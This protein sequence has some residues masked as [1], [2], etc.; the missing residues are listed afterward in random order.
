VSVSAFKTQ[1][2]LT[3]AARESEDAIN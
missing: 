2:N 1:I 3:I